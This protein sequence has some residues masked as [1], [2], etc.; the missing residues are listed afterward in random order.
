MTTL[1]DLIGR[2]R[3]EIGD[4]LQ[5]FRTSAECDGQTSW[6]DLPKQQIVQGSEIVEVQAGVSLTQL[7]TPDGYV[8]DYQLGQ[9]QL[10]TA[11]AN[12]A[13]LI[14]N[15]QCWAMFSD[16]ELT[17]H[18]VDA[19]N[20]HLL[21]ATITE[22]YQDQHGWITYRDTAMTLSNLPPIE[23]PLVAMLATINVLWTLA[24]DAASDASIQT[25]EGTVVDRATRY[26]QVMTQIGAMTDRYEE[27]CG[28]LN[29]GM[30]R[31]EMLDLRRVSKTTG[32][33]VPIF[34]DREF[35]DHRWPQRKL[36][37]IDSRYDDE[38]GIPSPIWNSMGP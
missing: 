29:V 18:I 31:V 7:S 20:Q 11:P 1:T 6:F 27:W 22:R 19:L 35:D 8:M 28:Q 26:Q 13:V 32:R 21:G 3:N 25:A 9:L 15:G 2:V 36:P 14:V 24:N 37:P 38:S 10:T 34:K 4:P 5:P 16:D 30:F 17:T 23:E 33:L 12:N